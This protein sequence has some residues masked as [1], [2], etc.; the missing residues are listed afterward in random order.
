[1]YPWPWR[2]GLRDAEWRVVARD[3]E[4]RIEDDQGSRPLEAT[5]ETHRIENLYLAASAPRL[6]DALGYALNRLEHLAGLLSSAPH[7][8]RRILQRGYAALIE[9][10]PT[11]QQVAQL[12]ERDRQLDLFDRTG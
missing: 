4:I 1:M 11:E 7:L 10:R 3:G 6:Y 5:D 9:A 12:R 2:R 8:D